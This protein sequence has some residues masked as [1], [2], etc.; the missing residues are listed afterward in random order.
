MF[1]EKHKIIRYCNL[2]TFLVNA[3]RALLR[4]HPATENGKVD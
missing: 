1:M 4:A 3:E 2:L